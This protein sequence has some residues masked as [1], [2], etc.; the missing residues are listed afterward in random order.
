MA[1]NRAVEH[2]SFAKAEKSHQGQKRHN[3]SQAEFH[4]VIYDLI[5]TIAKTLKD[6]LSTLPVI[7]PEY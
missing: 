7:T 1:D 4:P 6:P 2:R 3:M 5:V